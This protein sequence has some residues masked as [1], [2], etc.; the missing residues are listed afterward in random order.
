M[1]EA[2]SHIYILDIYHK[3]SFFK[4][5]HRNNLALNMRATGTTVVLI[6]FLTVDK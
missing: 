1:E 3:E 6:I 4:T 5:L 2:P